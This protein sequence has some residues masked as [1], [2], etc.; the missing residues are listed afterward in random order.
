MAVEGEVKPL[1]PVT[2]GLQLKYSEPER[3]ALEAFYYRLKDGV[4]SAAALQLTQEQY[5]VLANTASDVYN[6]LHSQGVSSYT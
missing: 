3:V 5:A 2:W 6:I 1:P 4:L